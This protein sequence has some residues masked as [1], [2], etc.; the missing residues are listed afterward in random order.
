MT[1]LTAKTRAAGLI[2]LALSLTSFTLPVEASSLKTIPA[3]SSDDSHHDCYSKREIKEYFYEE[4]HLT[5]I[6]VQKTHDRY[7]YKVSGFG[8]AEMAALA[9]AMSSDD[10]HDYIK[11]VFLYDACEYEVIEQLRPRPVN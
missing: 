5:H 2:A 4:Y 1:S 9:P 3:M 8:P 11:Y 6:K 10:H 7:I